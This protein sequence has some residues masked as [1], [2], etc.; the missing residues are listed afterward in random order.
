[1]DQIR[2]I[3]KVR[4]DDM[5]TPGTRK[6]SA[7]TPSTELPSENWSTERFSSEESS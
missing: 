2:N 6:N 7:L 4:V 5:K 1:M 3:I